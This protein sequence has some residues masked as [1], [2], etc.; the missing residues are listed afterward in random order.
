MVDRDT[1][2]H[3]KQK[4]QVEGYTVKETHTAKILVQ[5]LDVSVD[6]LEG[7]QFVLLVF[8]S[9]AKIQTGISVNETK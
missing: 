9:T 6:D 1:Q 5:Q 3:E 4:A 2:T 8:Y 7:Y